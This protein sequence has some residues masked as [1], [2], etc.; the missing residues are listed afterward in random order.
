M[1]FNVFLNMFSAAIFVFLLAKADALPNC[2]ASNVQLASNQ[3]VTISS[4]NYPYGF[5]APG[6]CQY[7]IV[8]PVSHQISYTCAYYIGVNRIRG[9]SGSIM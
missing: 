8:A 1:F 3:R 9:F 5:P 4:Q 6:G 7:T 2:Y